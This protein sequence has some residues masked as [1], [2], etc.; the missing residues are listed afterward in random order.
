M[1][2]I[3]RTRVV[4]IL[5][6]KPSLTMQPIKALIMT[7]VYQ[8]TIKLIIIMSLSTNLSNSMI[9]N[10]NIYATPDAG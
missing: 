2:E 4:A 5:E 3:A 1:Q 8:I 9:N 6:K 7:I 10:R